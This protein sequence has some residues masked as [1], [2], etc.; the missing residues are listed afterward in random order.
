MVIGVALLGVSAVLARSSRLRSALV[1][2]MSRGGDDE[3][4]KKARYFNAA[5]PQKMRLVLPAIL[6]AALLIS[7]YELTTS[8]IRVVAHVDHAWAVGVTSMD[9]QW[10]FIVAFSVCAVTIAL[11]FLALGVFRFALVAVAIEGFSVLAFGALGCSPD[12]VPLVFSLLFGLQIIGAIY[13]VWKEEPRALRVLA[14][15]ELAP[16]LALAATVGERM[17]SLMASGL[18]AHGAPSIALLAAMAGCSVFVLFFRTSAR[19]GQDIDTSSPH[20]DEGPASPSSEMIQAQLAPYGLSERE[21]FVL[22]ESLRGKSLASMAKDLGVSRSTAGTYRLRAYAKLNIESL[23]E[24]RAMFDAD[25]SVQKAEQAGAADE[26]VSSANRNVAVLGLTAWFVLAEALLLPWNGSRAWLY[27][28][29]WLALP[30][31]FLIIASGYAIS[32]NRAESRKARPSGL[33]I[34][35]VCA[36]LSVPMPLFMTG[37]LGSSGGV[38]VVFD[39][40]VMSVLVFGFEAVVGLAQSLRRGA[41]GCAAMAGMAASVASMM[42]EW[43]TLLLAVS[44]GILCV[45]FI[46][47]A[48]TEKR[49]DESA[50]FEGARKDSAKA[51][52]NS[53]GFVPHGEQTFCIVLGL[54]MV[55]WG[56]YQINEVAV[57]DYAAVANSSPV[58][59]ACSLCLFAIAALLV[60]NRYCVRRE[61]APIVLIVIALLI[62]MAVIAFLKIMGCN[63]EASPMGHMMLGF[64]A[65]VLIGSLVDMLLTFRA[66]HGC[67]S[68]KFAI[69]TM[70]I[71][72]LSIWCG[73][74]VF[75]DIARGFTSQTLLGTCVVAGGAIGFVGI[76][77]A[78]H[79]LHKRAELGAA[80][81][82]EVMRILQEAGLTQSEARVALLSC[83]GRTAREV[84]EVLC[85]ECSTVRSHL[86]SVYLKL[87]V[88]AKSEL[89][90]AVAALAREHVR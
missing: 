1:R 40:L 85:V 21:L 71:A 70:L 55:G 44:A 82:E 88:H 18:S 83:G 38:P 11:Y 6:G 14:C 4:I 90:V 39:V 22:S 79:T 36:A 74:A 78:W 7:M 9:P 69:P 87:A 86:R 81:S 31:V 19:Q 37:Q 58:L 5:S 59:F 34:A 16:L 29:A 49:G 53:V 23:D 8:W 43:Y 75:A 76:R 61:F 32:P 12:M 10:A 89:E 2:C 50:M 63:A 65:T 33:W 80:N 27:D 41:V 46:G 73:G 25:S 66:R 62:G 67:G 30:I 26:R 54:S 51:I 35:A 52:S 17:A 48:R 13:T 15:F 45:L 42:A 77:G 84:A 56:F 64:P 47:I 3:C 72:A 24:A 20:P 68:F 60:W 57:L 28:E